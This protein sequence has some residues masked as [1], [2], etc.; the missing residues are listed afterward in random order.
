MEKEEVFSIKIDHREPLELRKFT[1]AMLCVDSQYK[2]YL[3][4]EGWAGEISKLYIYEVKEG[5]IEIKFLKGA[6]HKQATLIKDYVF[7]NFVNCLTKIF[8]SVKKQEKIESIKDLKDI[9]MI[10]S[11]I[12][13]DHSSSMSFHVQIG[14]NVTHNYHISGMDANA[15]GNECARQMGLQ[16]TSGEYY[17]NQVLHWKSAVSKDKSQ[18]IDQGIIEEIDSDKKVKLVC[19]E[20]IKQTMISGNDNNPFNMFFIVDIEVKRVSG[21]I[22]AYVIHKVHDSGDIS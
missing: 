10:A 9:S 1:A 15:I 11:S 21:E 18:S 14:G 7:G 2:K 8:E 13:S 16:K 3:A 17:Q 4:S 5:S 22:V 19:S 12:S 20:E 6:V